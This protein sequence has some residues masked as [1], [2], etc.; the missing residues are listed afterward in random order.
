MC[1]ASYPRNT[2]YSIRFVGTIPSGIVLYCS[3]QTGIEHVISETCWILSIFL[4]FASAFVAVAVV[5]V[6]DD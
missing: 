3:M 5:V 4:Q 6:D 2:G 1:A